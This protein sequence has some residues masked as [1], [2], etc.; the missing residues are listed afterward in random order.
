MSPD[1]RRSR[2]R[3]PVLVEPV[4]TPAVRRRA[5]SKSRPRALYIEP[6]VIRPAN[7]PYQQVTAYQGKRSY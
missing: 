4:T 6:E 1:R 3:G 5:R 7:G 2:S